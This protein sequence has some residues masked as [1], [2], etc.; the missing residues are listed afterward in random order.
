MQTDGRANRK[1]LINAFRNFANAFKKLSHIK[2]ASYLNKVC[3]DFYR[4]ASEAAHDC[5]WFPEEDI[6]VQII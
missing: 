3:R 6:H 4:T 2:F 1:K 5:S